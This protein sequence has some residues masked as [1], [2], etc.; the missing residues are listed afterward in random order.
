MRIDDVVAL[1]ECTDV[2]DFLERVEVDID[3]FF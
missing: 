1:L 3:R 2:G